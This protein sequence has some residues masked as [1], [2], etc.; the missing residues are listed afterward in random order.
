M[1]DSCCTYRANLKLFLLMKTVSVTFNGS[2]PSLRAWIKTKLARR[3][4]D[5]KTWYLRVLKN[6]N[7]VDE[8][9][10]CAVSSFVSW[11][12]FLFKP[13]SLQGRSFPLASLES[14]SSLTFTCF[15][16]KP[17]IFFITS[18]FT[19]HFFTCDVRHLGM[20]SCMDKQEP[21]CDSFLIY[22]NL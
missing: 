2:T 13:G 21:K 1:S 17:C 11:L 15:Y 7:N 3:I 5:E 4:L 18:C 22:R 6:W 10:D 9:C 8:G 16:I 12:I 20:P 14:H 19:W